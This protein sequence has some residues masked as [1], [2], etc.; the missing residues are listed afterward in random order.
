[1]ST[2]HSLI[3]GNK[4]GH[5]RLR[6]HGICA[7]NG[8]SDVNPLIR[9]LSAYLNL[10]KSKMHSPRVEYLQ[11]RPSDW[12]TRPSGRRR[13]QSTWWN[14]RRWPQRSVF[15]NTNK[16]VNKMETKRFWK[17]PS[18]IIDLINGSWSMYLQRTN[19]RQQCTAIIILTLIEHSLCISTDRA[20]ERIQIASVV[21]RRCK[22]SPQ[23][24]SQGQSASS[25]SLADDLATLFF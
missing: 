9:V 20:I 24:A 18:I 3:S 25:E 16:S 7:G 22:A 19:K 12:P 13:R 5:P 2:S 1:M 17:R 23:V 14:P 10:S 8:R 15:L 6:C 11:C 21:A 4:R